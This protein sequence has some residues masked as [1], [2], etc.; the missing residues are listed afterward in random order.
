MQRS[1]AILVRNVEV[2]AL[3]NEKLDD[4]HVLSLDCQ[5]QRR[6]QVHVLPVEISFSHVDEKV[7]DVDVVV[8]CSEMQCSVAV[9]FLLLDDPWTVEF[10]Q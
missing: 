10:R 3:A 5:M 4:L 9:V 7:G 1:V 8:E 6:L 2:G